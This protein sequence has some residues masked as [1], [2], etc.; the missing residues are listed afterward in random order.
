MPQEE[1]AHQASPKLVEVGG[2]ELHLKFGS[3][4]AS[5]AAI[6]RHQPNTND[7]KYP[8]AIPLASSVTVLPFTSLPYPIRPGTPLF[9]DSRSWGK[10]PAGQLVCNELSIW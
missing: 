9:S 2:E 10:H 3:F 6:P 8:F 1:G 7:I 5:R 4:D